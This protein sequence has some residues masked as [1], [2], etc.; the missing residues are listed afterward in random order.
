MKNYRIVSYRNDN[1]PSWRDIQGSESDCIETAK[2]MFRASNCRCVKLIL[3]DTDETVYIVSDRTIIEKQN[4]ILGDI[5][6]SL[7][8]LINVIHRHFNP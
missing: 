7:Q 2:A 4:E 3:A 1:M 6:D 5:A 8:E